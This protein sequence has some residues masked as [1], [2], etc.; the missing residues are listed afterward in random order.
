MGQPNIYR[1]KQPTWAGYKADILRVLLEGLSM[2]RDKY[3]LVTGE[4]N[5][6]REL[7]FCFKRAV[8][9]LGLYYHLPVP[10]GNN[11]PYEG[12][13]QR[14]LRENKRPDFYWQFYDDT[15]D[16]P[17]YGDRHFIL[18]CKCLGKP[19]SSSPNWILN[20]NYIQYGITR[21][22]SEEHGYAKG[23]ESGAMVG[24]VES[25]DFETILCEVNSH[26]ASCEFRMPLLA[27]PIVGWQEYGISR[28]EHTLIRT[29]PASPFLL[30]HFW[31]DIRDCDLRLPEPKED[32]STKQEGG[33]EQRA[34]DK[35]EQSNKKAQKM[36]KRES[37]T[38]EL[39]QIELPLK[40]EE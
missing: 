20:R 10:E 7:F 11:P 32:K 18:E 19:R 22:L 33:E 28:L 39:M 36:Q 4:V 12:D 6:N 15:V 2:L 14:V 27:T 17:K 25:A 5:L 9:K 21:F 37:V 34:G 1:R 30:L 29:F 8:K 35:G 3:R 38:E 13:E 26:I 40:S 23:D 24:Y 31:L 16:D